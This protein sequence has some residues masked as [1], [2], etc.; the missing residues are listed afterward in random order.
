[1][2]YEP[3]HGWM[4]SWNCC[5]WHIQLP[6]SS[7]KNRFR[8]ETNFY[9]FLTL[10][11]APTT[12]TCFLWA[13]AGQAFSIAHRQREQNPYVQSATPPSPL[14]R[15]PHDYPEPYSVAGTDPNWAKRSA[16][17]TGLRLNFTQ[18]NTFKVRAST[19]DTLELFTVR[20]LRTRGSCAQARLSPG[21]P[22]PPGAMPT[23]V[24]VNS[25]ETA[26]KTPP[27]VI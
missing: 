19:K 7:G 8:R 25:C 14:G 9:P 11:C 5:I 3:P 27:C 23:R 2:Y 6:V 26:Y 24:R 4:H 12:N 18:I 20:C 10:P 22:T 17:D 13:S 21:C 15:H 16:T 1:M